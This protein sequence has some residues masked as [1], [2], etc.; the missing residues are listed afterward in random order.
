M[1]KLKLTLAKF[2]HSVAEKRNHKQFKMFGSNKLVNKY[3]C[4]NQFELV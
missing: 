2:L 1:I 4:F 3:G